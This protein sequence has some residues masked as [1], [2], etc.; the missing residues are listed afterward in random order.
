MVLMT[1]EQGYH[2]NDRKKGPKSQKPGSVWP[3]KMVLVRERSVSE[4]GPASALSLPGVSEQCMHVY[5]GSR[6]THS[7]L[8]WE[9]DWRHDGVMKCV[10]LEVAIHTPNTFPPQKSLQ[11]LSVFLNEP[12]QYSFAT[13]SCI[14]V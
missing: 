7:S 11:K 12:N 5:V 4:Y 10:P 3:W 9:E 6:C 1:N 2:I 13:C 8:V 14:V